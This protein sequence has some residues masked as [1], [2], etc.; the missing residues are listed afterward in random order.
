MKRKLLL[1]VCGL[2]LMNTNTV[3]AD[4]IY[5]T[6]NYGLEFTEFQYNQMVARLSEPHVQN[7]S[8]K[9]YEML[10]VANINED[11]YEQVIYDEPVSNSN[12]RATYYETGCKKIV[13]SKTCNSARCIITFTNEWKCIPAVKSYDVSGV[14]L[15]STNYYAQDQA[16]FFT[17]DGVV[18]N[19]SGSRGASNGVGFAF[20]VPSSGDIGYSAV[21]ITTDATNPGVVYGSYQHGVKS[22]SLTYALDFTFDSGGLGGVFMWD[23]NSYFDRMS[24]VYIVA[25]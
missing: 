13:I 19:P 5:Y 17:S 8:Y 3:Y 2:V 9:A 25:P 12:T 10:G 6:N 14:R 24:G 4:N 20:K 22:M 21:N 15:S 7:M 18:K 1:L 23:D 16:A 11:N